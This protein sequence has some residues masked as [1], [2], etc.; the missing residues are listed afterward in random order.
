AVD[1]ADAAVTALPKPSTTRAPTNKRRRMSPPNHELRAPA[2]GPRN[3]YRHAAVDHHGPSG[4]I[5]CGSSLVRPAQRGGGVAAASDRSPQDPSPATRTL[6]TRALLLRGL[7]ALRDFGR[8]P[9]GRF[10][11]APRDRL[12]LAPVRRA[13]TGQVPGRGAL[14]H[15]AFL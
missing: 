6:P 2:Q 14:E 11:G 15:D 10:V 3:V 5:R 12:E 7:H 8:Q 9:T 4:S 13:G 1:V